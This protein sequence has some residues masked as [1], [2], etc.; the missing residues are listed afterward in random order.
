V[1]AGEIIN[2]DLYPKAVE[3][4]YPEYVWGMQHLSTL[5]VF[6]FSTPSLRCTF[7]APPASHKLV[8]FAVS[9]FWL[10]DNADK[11]LALTLL[12]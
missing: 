10:C 6:F 1:F 11:F 12:V 2:D 8:F 9:P 4:F 7:L 3:Y 5:C